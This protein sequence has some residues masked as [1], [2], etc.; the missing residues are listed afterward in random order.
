LVKNQNF[1]L[2]SCERTREDTATSYDYTFYFHKISAGP[3]NVNLDFG[4]RIPSMKTIT[5]AGEVY[6]FVLDENG[7]CLGYGQITS[8]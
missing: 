5:T 2:I 4:Y 1:S 3:N 6:G 7:H 8:K